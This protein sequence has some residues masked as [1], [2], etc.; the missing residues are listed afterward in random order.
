MEKCS[1]ID[2]NEEFLR[3]LSFDGSRLQPKTWNEETVK[4]F[5]SRPSLLANCYPTKMSIVL[6]WGTRGTE[7]DTEERE[8]QNKLLWLARKLH[9]A[10]KIGIVVGIASDVKE[11]RLEGNRKELLI[12]CMTNVSSEAKEVNAEFDKRMQELRYTCDK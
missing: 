4:M 5:Q 12:E 2:L 9:A 8:T 11:N 3:L 1:K 10:V 6:V 7:G